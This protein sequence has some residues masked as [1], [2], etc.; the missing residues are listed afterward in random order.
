[1]GSEQSIYSGNKMRSHVEGIGTC[2]LVLSSGFVNELEKTLYVPS[3]FR[4]LIS[5]LR[6]V[7]FGYSFQFLDKS[8][9]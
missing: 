4:N 7:H 5:I 6:L 1:M 3:F 8:L 9:N 2:R